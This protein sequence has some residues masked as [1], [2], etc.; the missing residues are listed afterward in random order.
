M[1]R[2]VITHKSALLLPQLSLLKSRPHRLLMQFYGRYLS[3]VASG[4]LFHGS[5]LFTTISEHDPRSKIQD[6]VFQKECAVYVLADEHSLRR[7]YNCPIFDMVPQ[8]CSVLQMRKVSGQSN[9]MLWCLT[10]NIVSAQD[11]T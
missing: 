8:H 10:A 1:G 3:R 7:S 6:P 5:S 2:L 11:L 9:V 4:T